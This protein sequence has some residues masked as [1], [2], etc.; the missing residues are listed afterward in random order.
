MKGK[1]RRFTYWLEN[2]TNQNECA[3][4]KK[5]KQLRS[6][7]SKVLSKQR[8][9]KR[10]YF[11]FRR[12]S[13]MGGYDDATLAFPD[14]ATVSTDRFSYI[15]ASEAGSSG[16]GGVPGMSDD[17]I[18]SNFDTVSY[19][20]MKKTSWLDIRWDP[21]LSRIDLVVAIHGLLSS[22]LWLCAAEVTA[23]S[24][25]DNKEVL[26]AELLRFVDRI[27]SLYP[28]NCFHNWEHACQVTLSAT[29]LVKEY[30]E[31]GVVDKNPFL[32]F[33]TVVS[34]ICHV[35]HVRMLA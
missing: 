6:E 30:H 1:G 12:R 26:D 14:D 16:G 34:S 29:Y 19:S 28:D 21:Q 27:S 18:F 17:D 13:S 31:G 32:R 9:K 33:I 25:P 3:S 11:N 2:G 5:I 20:E 15:D 35:L 22:M 4:P 23:G 7:V 24:L 10:K 8:W